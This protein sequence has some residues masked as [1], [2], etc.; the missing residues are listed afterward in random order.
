MSSPTPLARLRHLASRPGIRELGLLAVLY[1]GYSMIRTVAS[2]DFAQAAGHAREILAL[3]DVFALDWERSLNGFVTEHRLLEVAS[4][5]YYA[6]AHY[7]VTPAVMFWLWLR[8]RSEYGPARSA[9]V[10]ATVAALIT[11]L[12]LPTAPPRLLGYHDTLALTADVGWWSD[13]AS[14]PAGMGHLTNQLAAMPSMHVGWAL[15]CAL[16]LWYFAR[17]PWARGLGVAHA[18]LTTL[19]VIGTG[20]HW[21]LDVVV[22]AA[23]IAVAWTALMPQAAPVRERIRAWNVQAVTMWAPSM[24]LFIPQ[25]TSCLCTDGRHTCRVARDTSS[26]P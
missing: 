9:F 20:N 17:S 16:V 18:A 3:E 13:S 10:A 5:F 22:G 4:A 2:D 11:F 25:P 14:A 24:H 19:V 26:T 7:L 6:A 23:M 1:I 21:T 12:I 15:W 8:H